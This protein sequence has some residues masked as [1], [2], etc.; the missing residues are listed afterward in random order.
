MH[1][2]GFLGLDAIIRERERQWYEER[3]NDE[4]DDLWKENELVRAAYCYMLAAVAPGVLREGETL[5]SQAPELW[6]WDERWWKPT[7]ENPQRMLVKAGALIAAEI[8]RLGRIENFSGNSE[9]PADA[10][11]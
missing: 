3:F 8:D 9:N 5:P 7:Y 4:H 10:P 1:G 11:I 2:T 6:P